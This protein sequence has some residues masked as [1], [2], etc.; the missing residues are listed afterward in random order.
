MSKIVKFVAVFGL[1]A[2]VAACSSG[3][4]VEEVIVTPV[5]SEP[6]FTGKYK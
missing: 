6:E 2:G 5:T 1:V 3:S 4:A